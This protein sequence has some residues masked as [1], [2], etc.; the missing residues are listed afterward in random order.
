MIY[1]KLVQDRD[2]YILHPGT[3]IMACSGQKYGIL[4]R[5]LMLNANH[6]GLFGS[7]DLIRI[8]VDKSKIHP[9][10]LLA[11]L[12]DPIIGRPYIIRNA[13]GTSIPHLDPSDIKSVK[14]PRMDSDIENAIADLMDESVRLSAEADRLENE[15]TGLAQEQINLAIGRVA[16]G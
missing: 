13:Y 11:F 7:H 1:S 4:G 3:I 12:N 2:K 14:V 6:E 5:A 15:A 16:E 9:G 8:K 10:Y